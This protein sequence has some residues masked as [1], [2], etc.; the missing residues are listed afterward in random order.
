MNR[1]KT[2]TA[3][4]MLQVLHSAMYVIITIP[5]LMRG[6][7][8]PDPPPFL[9]D[10]LLFAVAV[11][12][13]IASYGVWRNQRWGVLVTIALC[14]LAGLLHLPGLL[15]APGIIGKIETVASLILVVAIIILLL[16]PKPKLASVSR[17]V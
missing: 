8:R 1:P 11:L 4:A 5:F 14:V 15:F 2:Y 17:N 16:W 6:A 3:A 12:G 13:F 7:D 10:L 9:V